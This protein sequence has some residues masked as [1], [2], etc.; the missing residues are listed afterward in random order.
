MKAAERGPFSRIRWFCKDGA[1]LPPTPSACVSH[2]GG[3]QHGEW[4]AK[5]TALRA[6]GFLVANVLA[7]LDVDAEVAEP[8]F[9]EAYAQILVERF[10]VGTDNGWIYRRAQFYRG[11]VQAEDERE[12]ARALLLAMLEG[13]D[14]VGYRY[15]AL[16]AGVRLL[17]HGKDTAS[18]QQV[19]ARAATLADLDP[20]FARLRTKIH[21]TPG[22]PGRGERA[23][24][25]VPV[26]PRRPR[27]TVRGA[28][29]ADRPRLLRPAASPSGWS[30]TRSVMTRA[31]W[32]QQTLREGARSDRRRAVAAAPATRR[33]PPSSPRC[34]TRCPV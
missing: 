14:W 26:V 2:G 5:T 3:W 27:G 29:R 8:D 11:A 7:G 13:P 32:L 30:R 1:Q 20:T 19:R 18:I 34:A 6:E 17:P 23:R 33:A 4:S 16:R 28:R 25:F 12:G 31:P 24:A 21:G 22:G 9:P 10:L 15:P